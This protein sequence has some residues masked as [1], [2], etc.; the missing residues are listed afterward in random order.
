MTISYDWPIAKISLKTKKIVQILLIIFFSIALPNIVIASENNNEEVTIENSTLD[1]LIPFY[2]QQDNLSFS[3]IPCHRKKHHTSVILE[4]GYHPFAHYSAV[5]VNPLSG[6]HLT[7][8]Q[9]RLRFNA[10]IWQDYFALPE[11]DE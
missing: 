8:S 7:H 6:Y 10:K 9:N 5:G 1:L 3:P 11:D 4:S 2:Q